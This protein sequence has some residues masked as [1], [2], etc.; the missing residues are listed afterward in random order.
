[1][2][3]ITLHLLYVDCGHLH[4]LDSMCPGPTLSS[5]QPDEARAASLSQPQRYD[6]RNLRTTIN[7]M[8]PICFLFVFPVFPSSDASFKDFCVADLN[9][10]ESPAG[11]SCKELVNVTADD[12]M[13]SGLGGGPGPQRG[14]PHAHSP[15][16]DRDPC[17]APWQNH[18]GLCLLSERR[19]TEDTKGD[20]K[21]FPQGLVHFQVN[22]GFVDAT[23]LNFYSSSNPRLQILHLALFGNDL[24]HRLAEQST[25]LDAATVKKLKAMLGGSY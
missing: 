1:M 14:H 15:W 2:A 18:G 6:S 5:R 9:A 11:Y 7:K 23:G 21:V 25:F 22:P 17:G 8:L 4:D 20:A 12:F 16:R 13:F 10:P 19:I 24:P 3:W